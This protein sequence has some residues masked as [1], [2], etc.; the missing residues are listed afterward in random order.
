MKNLLCLSVAFLSCLTVTM[1]QRHQEKITP[2]PEKSRDHIT[3]PMQ[4]HVTNKDNLPGHPE[5]MN[6]FNPK[7]LTW[8]WDTVVTYDTLGL[9]HRFIQTFDLKGLVLNQYFQQWETVAWVNDSR[10]T[11]S[12]DTNGFLLT[13]L[14]EEW[15]T[16]EWV[17][18]LRLTFTY[19]ASG[20][21]LTELYER[22][23]TNEWVNFWRLF[24]TYDTNE[25]WL[26]VVWETWQTNTWENWFKYS[27]TYDANGNMLTQL[28]EDWETNEWVNNWRMTYTYDANGNMLTNL[29][30]NWEINAWV[31]GLRRSYT[32]DANGNMLTQLLEYWLTTNTWGNSMKYSYTYDTNG[33]RVTELCE[34]WQTNAWVNDNKYNWTYDANGNSVTGKYEVWQS[35]IWEPGM[36]L[37]YLF[38]QQQ[39]MMLVLVDIFAYCYRYEASFVSFNTGIDL[40]DQKTTSLSI[41]PN[42]A[43]EKLTIELTCLDP[44]TICTVN[45][46]GMDGREVIRLQAQGSQVEIN[47]GSL[48]GGLYGI[49]VSNNKETWFGKFIK[50]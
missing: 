28:C 22:W 10:Y 12:Y 9:R 48:P 46:Y 35:G 21:M 44:N 11:Y 16:N 45:I 40:G 3:N 5:K 19:D 8:N 32:Y 33:N 37:Q 26:T 4:S 43:T 24:F 38:I 13:L 30:E 23:Q 7:S 50:N 20:N 31:N 27:Y 34:V 36:G 39:E 17:N 49:R 2:W 6:L 18:D 1:G 41:F 29:H 47:V 15:Q 14:I 25:N 42:P